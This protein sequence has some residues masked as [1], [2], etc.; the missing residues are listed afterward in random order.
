M[1]EL[2]ELNFSDDC[3]YTET[4]EWVKKVGKNIKIGVTDYAQ[5]Q[6][7]DIVYIDLPETGDIFKKGEE[8]SNLES[9]KAVSEL[10][11]PISGEVVSVNTALS[12][13]P[14]LINKFP[15]ENGWIVLI[16]PDD[17]KEIDEL[18]SKKEYL[19]ILKAE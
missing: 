2:S 12:D 13:T 17:L 9:V 18:L 6:L 7:G 19:N 15:N 16:K 14:E 11:M 4:H 1:K 3:F 5:D 8:F 10:Y